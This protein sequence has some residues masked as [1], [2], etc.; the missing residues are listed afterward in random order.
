MSHGLRDSDF[1]EI[2]MSNIPV[3]VQ[4][5]TVRDASAADFP[6]TLRKVA[7]IGYKYVE[8]AGFNGLT[9]EQLKPIL[10]DAGLSAVAAHVGLDLLDSDKVESTLADYATVACPYVIVP[11]LPED[12]RKNADDYK[13]LAAFLEKLAHTAKPYGIKIGYHN[14]G[15]EFEQK[16]DGVAGE[17]ILIQGTS[18]DLVSFELDTYWA[19]H[20]GQDPVAFLKKHP[21]RFHQ[22]HIKD[23]DKS[24][25]S[26][27]E[28][29]TGLL[30]L[31]AIVAAAPVAGAKAF[32]VEQDVCK[33][34]PLESIKI[35]FDNLKAKGYA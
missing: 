27:A 11:Y 24:D 3:A 17:E 1:K 33:R 35:S 9:A 19:L 32:V 23:M 14:H 12:R 7:E 25:R 16:F 18:P 26:F 31:D 29:G 34:N 13:K 20:A 15:F 2:E 10:K 28:I 8:F 5:Y 22:I 6:G 21:G 4:L 30:P